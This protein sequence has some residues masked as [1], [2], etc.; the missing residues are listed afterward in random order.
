MYFY[1]LPL[2]LPHR[3]K[4]MR[5]FTAQSLKRNDVINNEIARVSLQVKERLITV[6]S[7]ADGIW[8]LHAI[9]RR[10]LGTM[11]EMPLELGGK[12]VPKDRHD[13]RRESKACI[14][15]E[16]RTTH[17]IEP[18]AVSFPGKH[19]QTWNSR[20]SEGTI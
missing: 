14:W 4:P 10:N 20:D 2:Y 18:S 6:H 17:S 5:K 8:S 7:A 13:S 3:F 12:L 19:R 9:G 16:W 11:C 15:P 1:S